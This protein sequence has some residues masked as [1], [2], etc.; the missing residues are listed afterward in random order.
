MLLADRGYDSGW[1]R[2]LAAARGAR[3]NIPQDAIATIRSASARISTVLG[4][5][6]SDSSIRS[7]SVGGSRHD[8]TT[9]GQLP[10]LHPA[11]LNPAMAAG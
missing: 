6:S 9:R 11:G 4:I 1:I 10:R 5:W 8:T 2:A 7:S 3:A